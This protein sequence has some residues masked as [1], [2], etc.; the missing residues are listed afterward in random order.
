MYRVCGTKMATW[1]KM[2]NFLLGFVRSF[3][4]ICQSLRIVQDCQASWKS[5]SP[6]RSQVPASLRTNTWNI[7]GFLQIVIRWCLWADTDVHVSRLGP[8]SVMQN[9]SFVR[10]WTTEL[11]QFF[12]ITFMVMVSYLISP[13]YNFLSHFVPKNLHWNNACWTQTLAFFK[14]FILMVK[15]WYIT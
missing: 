3:K 7:D 6:G 9:R 4:R 5:R 13:P 12:L 14:G 1:L 2:A 10:Q 11:Q 8:L 15:T